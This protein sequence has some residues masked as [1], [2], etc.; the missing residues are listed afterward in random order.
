MSVFDVFLCIYCLLLSSCRT[1]IEMSAVVKGALLCLFFSTVKVG[2]KDISK[3]PFEGKCFK[4]CTL[5]VSL[6]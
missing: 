2:S 5:L 6:Y 1:T 3:T 4:S